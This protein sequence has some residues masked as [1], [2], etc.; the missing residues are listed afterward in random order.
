LLAWVWLRVFNGYGVAGLFLA[1]VDAVPDG[2]IPF[3]LAPVPV[4]LAF[5]LSLVVVLTGT[6]Y[7][8][9]RAA[10]TAPREAMR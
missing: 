7:S 5:V 6:L 9:W 8:S 3:R 2:P 4:L 1:G 10:T